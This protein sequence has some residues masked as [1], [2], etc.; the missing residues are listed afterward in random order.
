ME[1]Q[2]N[3]DSKLLRIFIGENDKA[4]HQPLYEAILFAAKKQGLAGATVLRGIMAYGA[5]TQ[6]HTAKLIDIS[7]D[8]PI[9]VEIV[10][11]ED[12]IN[13][14]L[15]TVNELMDKAGCG[16]LVTIEKAQVLY[17]RPGKKK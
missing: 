5:S 10:D 7:Q 15:K 6:I 13:R 4:N 11:H 14:F 17:Y 1:P 3:P 8:L 16:G 9:V 2:L 12:K